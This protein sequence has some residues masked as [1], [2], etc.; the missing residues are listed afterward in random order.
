MAK[1]IVVDVSQLKASLARFEQVLA[2]DAAEQQRLN[3]L[4]QNVL[5]QARRAT[6]PPASEEKPS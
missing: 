5:D 2:Q 3:E 4:Q 1:L 6:P